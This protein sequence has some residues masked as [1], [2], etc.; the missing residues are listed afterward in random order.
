[1]ELMGAASIDALTPE[2]RQQIRVDVACASCGA[3]GAQI[4]KQSE[5][6]GTS[7]KIRQPHFRFTGPNGQDAH[8]ELCEFN[9]EA[10]KELKDPLINF[11][12]DRS[13]ET[14]F[15]RGLVCKGIENGIFDQEAIRGMRQW[16]FDL[17]SET[18]VRVSATVEAIEWMEKLSSHPYHRR[19]PFHPSHAEMPNFDWQE[20]AKLQFTEDHFVLLEWLF[21]KRRTSHFPR[22]FSRAKTLSE[23]H[24]DQEIFDR[25]VLK[26]FYEKNVEFACFFAKN[27]DFPKKKKTPPEYYRFQGAP[28]P[29]LALCALLLFVSDWSMDDA[30]GLGA[31]LIAAPSA[32]DGTLGNVMGLNPF[33]DYLAWET[34]ALASELAAKSPADFEY[35]EILQGIEARIRDEHRLWR[36]SR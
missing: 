3:C 2:Q 9:A 23:E 36:E 33:H 32:S 6:Q 31:K 34:L 20:A 25:S 10:S 5:A 12:T 30:I 16:F 11:A 21:E 15:V 27:S 26:P 17:K 14:R 22:A 35:E 4:V 19:W 8:H 24:F 1:M 29:L 13:A 28:V 7:T 18:R